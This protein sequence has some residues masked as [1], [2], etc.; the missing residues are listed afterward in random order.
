MQRNPTSIAAATNSPPPARC[1]NRRYP[2]SRFQAIIK[3]KTS[4]RERDAPV[5]DR[6]GLLLF[7]GEQEAERE[8]ER[9]R[10]SPVAVATKSETEGVDCVWEEP[11]TT[12]RFPATVT[13][14]RRSITGFSDQVY[15]CTCSSFRC[16]APFLFKSFFRMKNKKNRD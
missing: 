6:R 2:K 16:S 4:E 3:Q 1:N 11:R 9:E 14:R 8:R 7:A 12:T 13:R 5:V 10:K 15:T